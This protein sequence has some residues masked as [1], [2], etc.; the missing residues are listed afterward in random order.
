[1]NYSERMGRPPVYDW[2]AL[3]EE[4]RAHRLIYVDPAIFQLEM[5]HIFGGTWTYVAHES[6]I[7][8]ENDYVA[9]KLGTR[10]S[11]ISSA[12]EN[13]HSHDSRQGPDRST[14]RAP[15]RW[16]ET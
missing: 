15:H 4:E 13:S 8:K 5:T 2:D 1:M 9:R 16:R 6:E 3:V 11:V 7:P 12:T 10:H 14:T